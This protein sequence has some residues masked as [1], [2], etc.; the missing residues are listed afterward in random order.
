M[1]FE[2]LFSSFLLVYSVVKTL[3]HLPLPGRGITW[4]ALYK[5]GDSMSG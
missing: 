3:D 2:K 1:V 4:E 5:Q